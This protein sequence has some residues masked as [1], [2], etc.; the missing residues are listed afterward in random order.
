M[1][2]KLTYKVECYGQLINT[3]MLTELV[4]FDMILS[5]EDRD[6]PTNSSLYSVIKTMSKVKT[7]LLAIGLG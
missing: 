2:D 1:V 5:R 7:I 6:K 3:P 4:V